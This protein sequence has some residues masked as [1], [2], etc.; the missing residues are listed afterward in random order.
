M[1]QI[2]SSACTDFTLACQLVELIDAAWHKVEEDEKLTLAATSLFFADKHSW[3]HALQSAHFGPLV[4]TL[5]Q[6]L[7]SAA[8]KVYSTC[9]AV[10]LSRILRKG[11]DKSALES[12]TRPSRSSQ[13]SHPRLGFRQ[14]SKPLDMPKGC[15]IHAPISVSTETKRTNARTAHPDGLDREEQALL[16]ICERAATVSNHF[17]FLEEQRP[18]LANFHFSDLTLFEK[19]NMRTSFSAWKAR[20]KVNFSFGSF[21]RRPGARGMVMLL[22]PR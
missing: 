2:I 16:H 3:I 18:Q 17:P 19:Q 1:L 5:P 20:T 21:L 4:G 11:P 10:Y 9:A 15:S 13:H 6:T 22:M 7:E 14:Y 8:G 12:L